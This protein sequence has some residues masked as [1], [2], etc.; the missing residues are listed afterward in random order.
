MFLLSNEQVYAQGIDSLINKEIAL[1]GDKDFD[2]LEAQKLYYEAKILE[3]NKDFDKA[4][5]KYLKSDSLWQNNASTKFAMAKCYKQMGGEDKAL[6]LLKEAQLLDPSDRAIMTELIQTY[7][8]AQDLDEAILLTNS[9]LKLYPKDEA[10]LDYLFKMHFYKGNY[11]EALDVLTQLQALNVNNFDRYFELSYYKAK[12]YST[13][14]EEEHTI[15]EYKRLVK[16]F[17]DEAKAKTTLI[18]SYFR[19]GQYQK[20]LD[21]ID[22]IKVGQGLKETTIIELRT[23]VLISLHQEDEALQSLDQ[24]LKSEDSRLEVKLELLKQLYLQQKDKEEHADKFNNLWESLLKQNPDNT[25]LRY[26]YAEV[27]RLQKNFRAAIDCLLPIKESEATKKEY[28]EL[29]IG[30]AISLEDNKLIGDFSHS[31]LDYIKDD[32]RNYFYA[33]IGKYSLGEKKEA[34]QI[35]KNGIREMEALDS[36]NKAGLSMLYSQLG[37]LYGEMSKKKEQVKAFDKALSL[38]P[39]NTF[40]LNNYAY[41]LSKEEDRLDDAERMAALGVRLTPDN[42]NLLETYAWILYQKKSYALAG[43]YM[44]KAIDVAKQ[45]HDISA[46]YY[47]HAGYIL[48]AQGDKDGAKLKFEQALPLYKVELEKNKDDK[49]KK[50]TIKKAVKGIKKTLRKL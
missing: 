30:D 47:E 23:L 16:Q 36:P 14:K 29:L 8:Q 22:S 7:A 39:N 19:L 21:F 42:A 20:A 18:E 35:V 3:T 37:D 10:M 28:W 11:P 26:A 17:P 24:Y 12:V 49:S 38:N 43:L 6:D 27:L 33:S 2:K 41:F 44:N 48:L 50:R 32:W 5:I 4:L 45:S 34:M 40:T 25:K 9:W 15:A 46:I 31:A 1:K 13:L